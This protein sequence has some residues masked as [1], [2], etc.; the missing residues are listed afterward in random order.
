M[1]M[2]DPFTG[3]K[4]PNQKDCES[5]VERETAKQPSVPVTTKEP[6]VLETEAKVAADSPEES[7]SP[8]VILLW[9]DRPRNSLRYQRV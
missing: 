1:V 3:S 5:A 4:S 6:S 8:S 2:I 9:N 7:K